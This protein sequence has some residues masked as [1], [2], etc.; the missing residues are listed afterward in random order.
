[1]K[2][3]NRRIVLG[4]IMLIAL[5][6][7]AHPVADQSSDEREFAGTINNTLRVSMRLSQSGKTLSGSYAYER[8]GKSIRLNGEMTS[9]KE[10]Y[11]NEFDEGGSQT[12]KFE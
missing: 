6:V 2:Q 1:M 10:F 9:E 8:I 4:L 3:K 7:S 12:G 5:T 11:L